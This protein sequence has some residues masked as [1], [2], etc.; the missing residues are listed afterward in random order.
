MNPRI[1]FHNERVVNPLN[2]ILS[3]RK[4]IRQIN[5]LFGLDY[6]TI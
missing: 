6:L 1:T 4:V 5:A 3:S 2:Y